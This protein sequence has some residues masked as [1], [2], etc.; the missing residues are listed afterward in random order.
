MSD[1]LVC[2]VACDHRVIDQ[3]LVINPDGQTARF[4]VPIDSSSVSIRIN[5]YLVDNLITDLSQ[6][7]QV[8]P[9]PL[10]S[11]TI[12]LLSTFTISDD[13]DTKSPIL[14]KVTFDHL[15]LAPDDI[16]EVSYTVVPAYCPK[17]FGTGQLYD[18]A[19]HP[20]GQVKLVSRLGKLEQDALKAILTNL[21][22]NPFHPWIGTNLGDYVGEKLNIGFIS[23]AA[24][25]TIG[26]ALG[27]MKNTQNT[28]GQY[29]TLTPQE[30]LKRVVSIS[31]TQDTIDPT[32]FL[33]EVVLQSQSGDLVSI[34][35]SVQ[36]TGTL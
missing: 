10:G 31:V 3:I 22:S 36:T 13:L 18:Y 4:P 12:N 32:E 9:V 34:A 7:P 14:Q 25:A 6:V 1:D 21:T 28:Q 24:K 17:C 33:I 23:A 35:Q 5:G 26:N 16:V 8:G 19:Y 2:S 20:D 11:V 30:V 27:V 29:Q 15:I